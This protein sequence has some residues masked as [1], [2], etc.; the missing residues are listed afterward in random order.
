MN[1]FYLVIG[2]LLS[3]IF[4]IY[5][6]SMFAGII[7]ILLK[8]DVLTFIQ[9]NFYLELGFFLLTCGLSI[10]VFFPVFIKERKIINTLKWKKIS[11][12]YFCFMSLLFFFYVFKA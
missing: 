3:N 5:I 9:D 11:F 10:K 6:L 7:K 12:V 8:I 1:L 2:Y 4:S